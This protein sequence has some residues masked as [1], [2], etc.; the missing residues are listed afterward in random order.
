MK[1]K[2]LQLSL[3]KQWFEM[4]KA[5]IKTEDY[6]DIN[7]YWFK[8]LVFQYKKVFRYTYG[9]DIDLLDNLTIEVALNRI[10][11]D[12]LKVKMIGF[13]PYNTNIMTLGYPKSTD[14]ERI[15]RLE[16]KG[17]EIGYGNPEWGAEPNK[18]YFIIK[19]GSPI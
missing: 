4:T 2:N 8:R 11:K 14:T 15:L 18:L 13:N 3:K 16:H 9:F 5:G 7:E 1:M 12:N 6:R 17:I 19:H 10:V